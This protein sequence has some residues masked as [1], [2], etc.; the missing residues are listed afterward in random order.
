[1]RKLRTVLVTGAGGQLGADLTGELRRR[2]YEAPIVS[3]RE[4]D[5]TEFAAVERVLLS[6]RPDAVI[7]CAAY[8]AVDAA[9]TDGERCDAVNRLG[10]EHLSRVCA[11][12][13][14]PLLYVS[15]EY[16]FSGAGSEPWKPEDPPHPLNVYG[17]S[18][19]AGELAVRKYL[20]EYFIVR[21]S[22]LFGSHGKNFV[23]TML[24]LG[25]ERDTLSVVCDQVGSPTYSADLA[26]LLSDMIATDKYGIYHASNEGFCSWYDFACE[27]FRQAGMRVQ[28][29]PVSTAEYGRSGAVRPLNSRM[30]K[31]KLAENGFTPLPDWRDALGR[32]LKETEKP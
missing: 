24:R 32:Y 20:R 1:M 5:I 4:M 15:T 13:R 7:H 17:Q 9:E 30:D 28:V 26:V 3:S 29:R 16:V 10:T 11:A 23:S 14:I 22:W 21:I 19:Y 2:G 8:T 18:K 31:S 6:L 27:I 12:L 25:A